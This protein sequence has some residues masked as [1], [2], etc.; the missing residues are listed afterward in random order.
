MDR[1]MVTVRTSP[2]PVQ[3]SMCGEVAWPASPATHTCEFGPSDKLE[4]GKKTT[5]T[6]SVWFLFVELSALNQQEEAMECLVN[7]QSSLIMYSK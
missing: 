5:K 2:S 6:E 1:P 7:K 4:G 3:R